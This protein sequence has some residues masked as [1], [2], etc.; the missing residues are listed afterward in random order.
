MPNKCCVPRCRGNYK[1][2]SKVRIFRFP[3]DEELRQKWIRA[4]P[5]ENF[6]PTENTR[7]SSSSVFFFCIFHS[8]NDALQLLERHYRFSNICLLGTSS[9]VLLT[10]KI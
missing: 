9:A 7:V 3:K 1:N 6:L 5:R 2:G 8:M 4:I 10:I